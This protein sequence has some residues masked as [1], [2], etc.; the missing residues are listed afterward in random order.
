ME[1]V[2]NMNEE[3]KTRIVCSGGKTK[4]RW[5]Q[6]S[7]VITFNCPKAEQ[8]PTLTAWSLC[9]SAST[10]NGLPDDNKSL[11]IHTY[12]QDNSPLFSMDCCQR[13]CR[14]KRLKRRRVERL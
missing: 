10:Y 9:S 13:I 3:R 7:D 2:K 8:A 14:D 5:C 11:H 1:M 4:M 6:K 12:M